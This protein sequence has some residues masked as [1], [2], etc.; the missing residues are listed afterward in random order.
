[1][2]LFLFFT[3][4]KM[5]RILALWS[6]AWALSGKAGTPWQCGAAA[7]D[8]GF[9]GGRDKGWFESWKPLLISSSP[10]A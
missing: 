3:L 5:E 2:F 4:S 10:L 9:F 8:L 7:Q 6:L 1:M